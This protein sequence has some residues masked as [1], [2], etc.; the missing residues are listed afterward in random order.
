M[1]ELDLGK[2]FRRRRQELGATQE[3]VAVRVGASRQWLARVEA[4][5][6]NPDLHQLLRLCEVLDLTLHLTPREG[7][8][9]ASPQA[10]AERDSQKSDSSRAVHRTKRPALTSATSRKR[11]GT[12]EQGKVIRARVTGTAGSAEGLT[13]DLDRL[14]G[15]HTRED[16]A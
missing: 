12:G 5:T 14:L 16:L 6:G 7:L 4:G 13:A 9:G 3:A 15:Q 2:Q 8:R 1:S 11:P 10:A